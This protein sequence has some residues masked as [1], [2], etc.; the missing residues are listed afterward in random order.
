MSAQPATGTELVPTAFLQGRIALRDHTKTLVEVAATLLEPEPDHVPGSAMVPFPDVPATPVL[1]K[2]HKD[3]LA[4]LPKVFAKTLVEDRRSLATEE[5]AALYDERE[6]V[7]TVMEVLN[8]RVDVINE[9]VRT[10]VDVD[11]EERGIAVPK[12]HIRS[13]VVLTE[14]TPRDSSGHY[15]FASK[16]KPT[17]VNIP[18]TNEAFSLEYRAG[19]DG[20]V[21]IDSHHLLDL[22]EEGEITREQYLAL[23]SERRVFDEDKATKAIVKDPTL[24]EVIAKVTRRVAPTKPGTSLFIRKAN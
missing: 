6:T 11:H 21:T 23:T 12:D 9:N 8:G 15:I 24:L 19:R 10:H 14:A 22:Y 13:G 16:G 5:I 4:K 18:G 17:R 7:K 3:A 20:G 1:T 2:E